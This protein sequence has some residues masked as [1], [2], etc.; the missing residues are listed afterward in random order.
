MHRMT[1][2]WWGNCPTHSIEIHLSLEQLHWITP[3]VP[4]LG[5]ANAAEGEEIQDREEEGKKK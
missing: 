1:E 5:F 3:S 4:T 2:A